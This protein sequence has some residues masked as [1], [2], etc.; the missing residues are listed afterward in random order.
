M[1]SS[2]A[3]EA[4]TD[5]TD[6]EPAADEGVEALTEYHGPLADAVG[7]FLGGIRSG[8]SYCGAHTLSGARERGEFIRVTGTARARAGAHD[9]D[10]GVSQPE[11]PPDRDGDGAE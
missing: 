8:L 11:Q 5:K 6:A 2:A 4:R 3:G 10:P 1:A 9:V 7:E